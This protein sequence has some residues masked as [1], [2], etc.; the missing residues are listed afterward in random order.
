ML[1][2]A[3][4][5]DDALKEPPIGALSMAEAPPEESPPDWLSQLHADLEVV[6]VDAV[7]KKARGGAVS[8]A[9]TSAA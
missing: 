4:A 3:I 1:D 5:D 8:L 7:D 6:E 2:A 9:D